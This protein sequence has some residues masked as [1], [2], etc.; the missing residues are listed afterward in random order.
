VTLRK[1]G[2]KLRNHGNENE[3]EEY[4]KTEGER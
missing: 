3:G 1:D 4:I 2:I